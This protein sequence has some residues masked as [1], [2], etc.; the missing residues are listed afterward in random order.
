MNMDDENMAEI[1]RNPKTSATPILLVVP[2]GDM[3]KFATHFR[4]DP[5][6][7]LSRAGVSDNAFSTSVENLMDRGAGGRL[8]K[9]DAEIYA[10][11]S[12]GALQEIALARPGAY[13]IADAE[14][15]L[16]DSMQTR[17]G[18]ARLKVAEIL[19]QI[20]SER[21][22]QALLDAALAAD[23]GPD[24]VPLMDYTAA[25]IRRWGNRSHRRHVEELRF[26]I[27]NSS[28]EVSDAAGRIHGAM[29]LSAEESIPIVIPEK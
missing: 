21:A 28:G 14:S 18:G 6:V 17:T 1:R 16:I 9:I 10:M 19:S 15:S 4:T 20:D 12:L 8:T 23:V 26:L 13:A 7:G 11:E 27:N 3:P 22:Q 5:L 29:N 24:R 25:S 2:A